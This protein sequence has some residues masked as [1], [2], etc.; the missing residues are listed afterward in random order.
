M[1]GCTL[2]SEP[3]VSLAAWLM[4][5]AASKQ[6]HADDRPGNANV[7]SLVGQPLTT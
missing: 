1:T 3:A 2:T 7:Y 4:V 5:V 6:S